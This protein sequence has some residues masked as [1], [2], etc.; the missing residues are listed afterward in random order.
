LEDR[1]ERQKSLHQQNI[2]AIEQEISRLQNRQLALEPEKNRL[3]QQLTEMESQLTDYESQKESLTTMLRQSATTL[4][5][6]GKSPATETDSGSLAIKL[7]TNFNLATA[8]LNSMSQVQRRSGSFFLTS[9]KK[10]D[11][12]ITHVGQI[13]SFGES[14]EGGGALA[15]TG[16]DNMRIWTSAEGQVI[17][18]L[19]EQSGPLYQAFLYDSKDKE[20]TAKKAKTLKETLAAGGTIGWIITGLGLIA[21]LTIVIKAMI[22]KRAQSHHDRIE[23]QLERYLAEKDVAGA[24]SLCQKVGGGTAK[25]IQVALANLSRSRDQFENA[26]SEGYIEQSH[27]LERFG[28]FIIV[29]ATVAPLLG[30]LGTVTG[31]ISTF[32]IITEVGTGDPKLL[33]SGISE[34]LVT[35]MLGL[36]VAIPTL[37]IGNMLGSWA[38]SLKSDMEKIL[39]KV[40][41]TLGQT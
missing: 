26:I 5:Q 25:L 11:G 27:K 28:T 6:L 13:A 7:A 36:S 33:S 31:M 4:D 3:N 37:L 21:L 39:L 14:D 19:G 2:Q 8:A 23:S 29:V 30:L 41:N 20:F 9:G 35:T 17:P 16:T 32:D 18:P 22:L 15:P 40:S 1:L 24:Q 38:E 10:V 34:A 12:Q